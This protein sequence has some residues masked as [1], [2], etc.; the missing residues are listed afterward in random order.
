M[1]WIPRSLNSY[2]DHLSKIIDF[3]DYTIN[4]G[5]F[6]MLDFQ[7]GPHTIDRFAC[8]NSRFFQPGK[9]IRRAL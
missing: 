1:E 3:D 9:S 5:I 8:S 4:D 6:H 7:W 2:A